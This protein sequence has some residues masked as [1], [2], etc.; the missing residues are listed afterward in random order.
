MWLVPAAASSSRSKK[1]EL[2]IHWNMALEYWV[3]LDVWNYNKTIDDTSRGVQW[4]SIFLDDVFCGTAL[5]RKAPGHALFDFKHTIEFSQ[6]E[7]NLFPPMKTMMTTTP[8]AALGRAMTKPVYK[9]HPVR[10][11]YEPPLL[12]TGFCLKV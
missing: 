10:Q 5:F 7:M 11:D 6:F 3:A 12:P 4:A 9:T 8:T 1:P 2:T